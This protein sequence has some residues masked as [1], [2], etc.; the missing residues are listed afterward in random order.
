[1]RVTLVLALALLVLGSA[2][3]PGCLSKPEN[4]PPTAIF[5]ASAKAVNVGEDIIFDASNSTDR[6]GRI[7]RYHWDFGD[8]R[9]D[10][11]VSVAHAY[12]SGGDYTVALTVTDNEGK[13]DR[14]NMTV[15]IN[16][17]P[18]ARI[19]LP[20]PEAKVLAEVS[21]SGENSSDPD[22]EIVSWRWSFEDGSTA[23]GARATHVFEDVGNFTV[24]LTV[25]D[26]FG[27]TSNASA[28]VTIVLRTF[29]V[30]WAVVPASLP[31]LS[32]TSEENSTVNKSA[33]L[34]FENMTGVEVRLTWQDDIRHW[35]LGSYNDDFLLRVVD[36]DNN[37]QYARDMSGNITLT[38][39]LSDP[40]APFTIRA[41]S[42]AEALSDVGSKF[43][44]RAGFG[45]WTFQVWLGEA[46]G[47]QD[48]TG[49]DLD[50]GNSWKLDLIYF[51]YEV[52]VTE[53]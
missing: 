10:M 39:S 27:A 22:G 37:T 30:S 28:S 25:W 29:D 26:D 51:R 14:A 13:K 49:I 43:A 32:G 24:V 19:E 7:V 20:C 33:A 31:Q 50:T 8:A 1:M 3:V 15:H 36:P 21:L 34:L 4:R 18:I 6:D 16:E 45:N 47:A 41:R 52:A 38:F 12:S 35:L 11:G 46:G 17:F 44:T 5:S 48:L 42:A 9:E 40:P 53:R 23:T 2:L